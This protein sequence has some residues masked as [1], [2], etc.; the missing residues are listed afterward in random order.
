MT[1]GFPRP[2]Q[3]WQLS[4]RRFVQGLAAGGG[5]AGGSCGGERDDRRDGASGRDCNELPRDDLGGTPGLAS[6]RI[7]GSVPISS[8]A[9]GTARALLLTA[10]SAAIVAAVSLGGCCVMARVASRPARQCI[11]DGW[12]ALYAMALTRHLSSR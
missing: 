10:A 12:R 7:G 9:L 6:R 8:T 4:R 2:K 3:P 11:G 5:E 1:H